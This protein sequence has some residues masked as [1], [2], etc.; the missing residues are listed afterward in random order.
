[1][2][3]FRENIDAMEGYAPG[4]QPRVNNIIKLN[5]NENP[6]PP[7]PKAV[8]ALQSFNSDDLR[9]YPQPLSLPVLQAACKVYGCKEDEVI[10]GNGSDD[11]LTIL[12]RS[13]AGDGDTIGWLNPSYSLY[14][15]LANLQGANH[16]F[17]ELNEDFTLPDNLAEK[18]KDCKLFI[19]TNPNA[20][21]GNSFCKK[22]IRA[23]TKNF[24]GVVVI[25]E[26]YGDFANENCLEL[27]K[28]FPNL[29]VTRSF[30]K[31][32]S[33]A[34]LRVGLAFANKNLIYGM[35]KVKDSYNVNALSQTMAAAALLD[36]EYFNET[37]AK[38]KNTRNRTAKELIKMG[39]EV[40]NSQ[41]NFIFAAPPTDAEAYFNKLKEKNIFTRYFKGPRTSRFIRITIGTDA[42]MD[43]FLKV[44]GEILK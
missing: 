6:Y 19:I 23:F 26:A 38:I 11:I 36:Q 44:S 39:F 29:V 33:L 34:G 2:S 18:A 17:V 13:F 30:S 27:Y 20:P 14:P 28:E 40:L 35:M 10:A 25:D 37:V 41:T 7:S 15:V 32:Y 42:E 12:F 3:Y 8:A 5:T 22:K 4:E 16:C 31:S 24:N 1:M 43:T 9:K 21:T